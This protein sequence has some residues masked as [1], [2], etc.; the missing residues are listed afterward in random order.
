VV[1]VDL[2]AG[3]SRLSVVNE[4]KELCVNDAI[5]LL[6]A[7]GECSTETHYVCA[8]VTVS[9][10]DNRICQNSPSCSS[11]YIT[12]TGVQGHAAKNESQQQP[13]HVTSLNFK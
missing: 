9:S 7:V 11:F 3:G 1:L 10:V 8:V 5:S 13:P 12:E 6:C 2:Y 4:V